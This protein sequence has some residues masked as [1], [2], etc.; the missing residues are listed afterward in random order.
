MS[1]FAIFV[2]SLIAALYS[3]ETVACTKDSFEPDV[4]A[5]TGAVLVGGTSQ[6]RNFC[7]DSEDW[8]SIAVCPGRAYSLDTMTLGA[9]ADTLIELYA[10]DGATLLQAD[11]DPGPDATGHLAWI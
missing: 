10:G 8:M 1:R 4:S 11:S 9:A 3:S 2:A 7:D 5:P 6:Q